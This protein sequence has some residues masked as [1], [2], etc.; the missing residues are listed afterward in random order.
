VPYLVTD[1]GVGLQESQLIIRHLDHLDGNPVFDHPG[2]AAGWESRRLEALARSMLDG[3]SVWGRELHRAA[4]ER[5]PTIIDHERY[6][7][8]R[9]AEVWEAEIDNPL[10]TGDLNM[11]QITLIA[12]LLQEHGNPGIDWRTGH[13]KL[14]AW[15]AKLIERPSIAANLPPDN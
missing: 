3:Q 15:A 14:E 10:M 13:P 4:D 11:A 6:R 5:S 2:R 12:T 9:M 1:E 7:S 8:R